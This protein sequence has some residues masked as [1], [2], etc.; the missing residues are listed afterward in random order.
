MGLRVRM[1]NA[2]TRHC[3]TTDGRHRF[4]V[5]T[6]AWPCQVVPKHRLIGRAETRHWVVPISHVVRRAFITDNI[7][8]I[9]VSTLLCE[10]GKSA[11]GL[12]E[13]AS[14]GAKGRFGRETLGTQAVSRIEIFNLGERA[15]RRVWWVCGFGRFRAAGSRLDCARNRRSGRSPSTRMEGT[16]SVC[17]CVGDRRPRIGPM[18][19]AKVRWGHYHSHVMR[20][21][22]GRKL[23]K[24]RS[25][26]LSIHPLLA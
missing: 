19:S 8:V 17:N 9:F 7:F 5:D 12:G 23:C 22:C 18:E 26:N 15:V 25:L 13:K 1:E 16:D 24:I 11:A 10:I 2:W 20:W 21:C 4:I 3:T 14:K 6:G